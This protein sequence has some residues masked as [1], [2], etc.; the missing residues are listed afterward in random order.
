MGP[1]EEEKL[2]I[3]IEHWIEHNAEHAE[4]FKTLSA[5]TKSGAHGAVSADLLKAAE[6]LEKANQ[7]LQEAIK[8]IG[9]K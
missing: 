3:R 4:E 5:A 8:K 1:T 9:G 6:E 7:W 2:R